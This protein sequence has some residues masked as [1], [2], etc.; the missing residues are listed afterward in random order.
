MVRDPDGDRA[1]LVHEDEV[2]FLLTPRRLSPVPDAAD[3]PQPTKPVTLT[4][5]P[6][7]ALVGDGA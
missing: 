3:E 5:R 4:K 1:D 6:E 7:P 2:G